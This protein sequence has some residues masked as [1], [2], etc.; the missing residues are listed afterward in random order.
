MSA[1]VVCPVC[2]GSAEVD[3]KPCTNCGGQTMGCKGT[4]YS[5]INCYGAP[6]K[7][8]YRIETVSKCYHKH[9]CIF[10]SFSFYIDS[11]D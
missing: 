2:E 1:P 5:L 3:E 6:C 9:S 11:G 8:N 4:G 10:C 7:H